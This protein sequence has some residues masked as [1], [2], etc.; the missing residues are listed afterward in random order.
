MRHYPKKVG[1]YHEGLSPKQRIAVQVLGGGGTKTAAAKRANVHRATVDRWAKE[2]DFLAAQRSYEHEALE[3]AAQRLRVAAMVMIDTLTELASPGK[4]DGVRLKAALGLLEHARHVPQPGPID[5]RLIERELAQKEQ[6][7]TSWYPGRSS[8]SSGQAEP[9]VPVQEE[10]PR[11]EDEEDRDDDD[12]EEED[13]GDLGDLS[14]LTDE[15]FDRVFAGVD[16]K[17]PNFNPVI[18]VLGDA[19]LGVFWECTPSGDR[20]LLRPIPI[21][22]RIVEA[23]QAQEEAKNHPPGAAE[24]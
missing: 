19:G 16:M 9:P 7:A 3:C 17:D 6:A 13:Y 2:P 10:D 5:P 20:R 22:G 1:L 14:D 11:E 4:P 23:F 24:A 12:D 15:Q 18:H 21:L 8:R